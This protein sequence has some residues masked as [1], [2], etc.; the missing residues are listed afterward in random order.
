MA[1]E[2]RCGKAHTFMPYLKNIV[3]EECG[4]SMRAEVLLEK[5]KA[6]TPDVP[7]KMEPVVEVK[8]CEKSELISPKYQKLGELDKMVSE[9][10]TELSSN[11][12]EKT[13]MPEQTYQMYF[14]I[15]YADE[16]K[17]K[18]IQ[19]KMNIG[20]GNGGIVSHLKVQNEIRMTDESSLSYQQSKGKESF[21]AYMGEL[22][23]MQEHVL[24]Y[25]QSF[26]SL[27]EKTPEHETVS[28][29]APKTS[30]HERLKINKEMIA[31]QQGKDSREKGA[32]VERIFQ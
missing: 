8:F 18:N 20:D 30:I 9:L 19:G 12:N 24:P 32:E 16:D 22:T 6:Y 27:E 25:L 3:E 21:Q 13:G 23:D 10:D 4:E 1:M 2:L 28:P 14:T 31:A 15:Y 5:L 29:P 11:I 7:E 26:C 17:I